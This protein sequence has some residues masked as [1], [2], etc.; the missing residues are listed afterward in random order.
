MNRVVIFDWK[1]VFIIYY[2]KR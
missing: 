1:I 2:I